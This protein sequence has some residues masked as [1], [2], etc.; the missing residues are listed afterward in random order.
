M[1]SPP[2]RC[3]CSGR[4]HALLDGIW[5]FAVA[6]ACMFRSRPSMPLDA[7]CFRTAPRATAGHS[8]GCGTATGIATCG[9]GDDG[10]GGGILGIEVAFCLVGAVLLLMLLTLELRFRVSRRLR[11]NATT[12][13]KSVALYA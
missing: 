11:M 7:A 12:V 4:L 6:I 3:P 8:A 2:L 5:M 10:T 9:S 1:R 13:P